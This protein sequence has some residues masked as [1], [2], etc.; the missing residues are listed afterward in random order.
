MVRQRSGVL[1]LLTAQVA[2]LAWPLLGGFGVACAALEGFGRSLAAELS[3]HG[4]R[5]I[6]LRSSGSPDAANVDAAWKQHARQAQTDPLEWKAD[7]TERTLLRR[8]PTLNE[9]ANV[10]VLMASDRA[11]VVTGAVTNVSCGEIVD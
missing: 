5:V 2:R 6:C 4:V 1:L 10:A 7:M 8:L 11:C 3:P 9:V